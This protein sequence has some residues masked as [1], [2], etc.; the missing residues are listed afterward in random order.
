MIARREKDGGGTR[1]QQRKNSLNKLFG[2]LRCIEQIAGDEH[3]VGMPLTGIRQKIAQGRQLL[4]HSAFCGVGRQELKPRAEMQIGG[5]KNQGHFSV[6]QERI[7]LFQ[8][9][10]FCRDRKESKVKQPPGRD[11]CFTYIRFTNKRG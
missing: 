4:N 7:F 1:T 11:D 9:S 8:Y 2:N 10:I 3:G 6:L 5:V